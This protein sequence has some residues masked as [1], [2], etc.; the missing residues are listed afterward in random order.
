MSYKGSSG[1]VLRVLGSTKAVVSLKWD[2]YLCYVLSAV[3]VVFYPPLVVCCSAVCFVCVL[4]V[5]PASERSGWLTDTFED[6]W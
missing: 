5:G 4:S 1:G 3:S 2:C 6:P